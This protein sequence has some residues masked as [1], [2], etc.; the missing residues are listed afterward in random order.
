MPSPTTCCAINLPPGELSVASCSGRVNDRHLEIGAIRSDGSQA[1]SGALGASHKHEPVAGT[2]LVTLRTTGAA[3]R[4]IELSFRN[5]FGAEL[6]WELCSPWI[7][8]LGRPGAAL[9]TQ[10]PNHV[11]RV[12]TAPT[13]DWP[14]G[15][16]SCWKAK[17][18]GPGNERER[19]PHSRLLE[20]AGQPGLKPSFRLVG[21][22]A[23]AAPT[24]RTVKPRLLRSST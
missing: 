22:Q 1:T 16:E 14:A 17:V 11:D 4:D 12:G 20:E 18:S 7:P 5:P 9:E 13:Q 24:C 8:P 10:F 23:I 15:G 19:S 21:C 3:Y 6:V 2:K